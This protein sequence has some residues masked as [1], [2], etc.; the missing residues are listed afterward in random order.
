MLYAEP[1]KLL[2]GR[3]DSPLTLME[4]S[5]I[6][7]AGGDQTA[8]AMS[9]IKTYNAQATVASAV[10]LHIKFAVWS[11]PLCWKEDFKILCWAG[12]GRQKWR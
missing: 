6:H 1:H 4:I 2:V 3:I 7:E 12:C 5:A 9:A 11:S 10:P 8:N